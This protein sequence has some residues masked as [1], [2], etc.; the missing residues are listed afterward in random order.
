MLGALVVW[1]CGGRSGSVPVA[2]SPVAE[3]DV[4]VTVNAYRSCGAPPPGEA[5]CLAIIRSDVG[6]GS[7]AGYHGQFRA[8]DPHSDA[9]P[10]ATPFGYTPSDLASAYHLPAAGGA[11]QTVGIVDAFNDPDAAA[12]LAVYREQFGL[13]ACTVQS[14]CLTIV[15]QTGGSTLPKTNDTWAQE[16]SIDLDMVSAVCPKCHI[17]LVEAT[18]AKIPDFEAAENTAARLGATEISNSYGGDEGAAKDPAYDHRGIIITAGA[19]DDGTEPQFPA[20]F[21]TVVA[22]G[23]TTLERSADARGWLENAWAGTG[24]G[25]SAVVA[26]P[27]WQ[28]DTGCAKRTE[29]D[30]SAVA[31]P[32]Y[33]V[34]VY[35]SLFG[36][37]SA[38]WI[39]GGGTSVASPIIAATYAL[40]GNAAKLVAAKR[41]WETAGAHLNDV[42][43]GS[44]G[45]CSGSYLCTAGP[46]YDG[47]TGWGTPSGIDAF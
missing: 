17:L 22:V 20:S 35:D 31:N 39:D 30:V 46:G 13:P 37:G 38:G 9:D 18:S 4:P 28:T 44:D 41:I 32:K 21:S 11:G 8:T 6:G 45:H 10:E 24:G 36:N 7:P 25:C 26:K 12:D 14:G 33:G 2:F 3:Q 40:A 34:A 43:K 27:A 15:D 47:P 19:G 5:A 23:G 16:I 1:G 42:E 29:V